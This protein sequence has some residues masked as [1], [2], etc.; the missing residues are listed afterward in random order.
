VAAT[1]L[2]V[3]LAGFGAVFLAHTMG[4]GLQGIYYAAA[5]AMTAYALV[6]AAAIRLGAW[7][8]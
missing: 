4:L 3:L 7:R 1:I 8:R 6:I 5:L 2:R